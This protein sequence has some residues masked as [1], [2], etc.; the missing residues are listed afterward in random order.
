MTQYTVLGLA[1]IGVKIRDA[2]ASRAFYEKLG[3]ITDVVDVRP[4]GTTLVFLHAGTCILELI[5]PADTSKLPA[6]EGTFAHVCLEVRNIEDFVENLKKEGMV[7]Q[8]AKINTL[9]LLGGVK[10][11][12]FPGPDGEQVELFDYYTKY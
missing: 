9:D 11:I 5:Q 6:C 1:H 12:F 2:Q 4:N 3:F 8:D 10:N 7:G